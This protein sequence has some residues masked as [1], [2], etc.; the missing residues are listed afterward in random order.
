MRSLLAFLALVTLSLGLIATQAR[1]QAARSRQPAPYSYY[2]GGSLVTLKPSE[3]FV[4]VRDRGAST[5]QFAAQASLQA[6]ALSSRAGFRSRGYAIYALPPQ[7][8]G[9]AP[10]AASAVLQAGARAAQEVQPVFPDGE[11]LLVPT[12]EALVG[13]KA[14]I[15]LRDARKYLLGRRGTV[16]VTA[17][18][19]HSFLVRV[20]QPGNG[21]IFSVARTLSA[22][23]KIRYAEPNFISQRT[24]AQEV[25]PG[26]APTSG[27][28]PTPRP[29]DGPLQGAPGAAGMEPVRGTALPSWTTVVSADFESNPAGWTVGGEQGY[30]S[31]RPGIVTTRARGGGR[32]TY[33]TGYNAATQGPLGPPY[34]HNTFNW[35]LSPLLNLTGAEEAYLEFWYYAKYENPDPG[36]GQ[37]YDYGFVRFAHPASGSYIQSTLI[38]LYPNSS[39]V[40]S[41]DLTIDPT[42]KNG[43]RRVLMRVPPPLLT[44]NV[45]AEFYFFSDDSLNAEGLYLDD[46]RIVA[47]ADVDTESISS[48]PYSGRQY[49]LKNSGQL[50][51]LGGDGNDLN[52]PEAWAEQPVSSSIVVAVIDDGVDLQHPDLNLVGGFDAETGAAG[53]GPKDNQSFHGTACAGNVGAKKDNGIGVAGTAPGVKIMPISW[54]TFAGAANAF[55]LAVANGAKV[56]TN[57]WGHPDARSQAVDD[58]IRNALQA[59]RVVLFAG[60]NGPDRPP[61]TYRIAWPAGLSGS[62]DTVLRN[63]ISVG[64]SSPTDEHKG[65]GSS[66]GGAFA[67][68]SYLAHGGLDG[69]DVCAPGPWSY[70]TD[71]RGAAGY[72]TDGNTSGVHPD[73][74][75]DFGGTSSAT[76]KVAG[77]VALLLS[78]N[79]SL[80]PAEVKQLLKSTTKDIEQAG[81]D[82]KTGSG[83][84]DALAALRA[85][86]GTTFSVSGRVT[87]NGGG[88]SDVVVSAGANK[89]ATTNASGDYTLTGLSTGTYTLTPSRSGYTF[90]PA[91]RSVTV[92]PSA[93]GR[94]FTATEA[95]GNTSPATFALRDGSAP[96]GGDAT[97][98]L[99]FAANGASVT[100]AG[101]D[102]VFDSTKLSFVSATKGALP[103]GA[104]VTTNEIAA[105]TIRFAVYDPGGGSAWS[106]GTILSVKLRVSQGVANGGTTPVRLRL[107]NTAADGVQVS[108]AQSNVA[109]ASATPGTVTFGVAGDL[110]GNGLLDIGD[111]QK[112]VNVFLGRDTYDPALHDLNGNGGLDIGDVQ[113]LVNLFLGRSFAPPQTAAK[114]TTFK[115]AFNTGEEQISSLAFDLNVG[116]GS[117]TSVSLGAPREDLV[118]AFNPMENGRVRV[119]LYSSTATPISNSRKL[120][121]IRAKGLKSFK[122]LRPNTGTAGADGARPDSTV[123][124]IP[125]ANPK[126]KKR[127]LWIG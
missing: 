59:N 71:I 101:F 96:A 57:S 98:Q 53:G 118:V 94:D 90:D 22:L 20:N 87:L 125:Y 62:N 72:N 13:F 110:N 77:I 32:S 70:T 105:G 16:S 11:F 45:R 43:W 56:I 9:G 50:A 114:A 93:T 19:D 123:V 47:T 66:D 107:P 27:V 104:A 39:G 78:R 117:V 124:P 75:H 61:F 54:S 31:A 67:G 8:K 122:P 91:T 95:G 80:T 108:D 68:S 97:L 100:A 18:L 88:L 42:T 3:R 26:A 109:N 82:D 92:G 51:A 111:V 23:P 69:P 12:D 112:I 46:V 52:V 60:G 55:A 40:L 73:Y 33:M 35:L 120:L 83:R 81:V 2:Y 29:A 48:D 116:R 6:H 41:G 119:V 44:S 15:S 17:H 74:T 1:G 99:Q 7:P 113:K 103:A 36:S 121:I 37:F 76:P 65:V 28:D 79:P 4:A 115:V 30:S 64:M 5:R 127:G 10:S 86:P 34:P 21:R 49:E 38:G 102:L 25:M 58:Q 24:T 85:V 84:V 14:P 106:S 89:S 126:K 63:V